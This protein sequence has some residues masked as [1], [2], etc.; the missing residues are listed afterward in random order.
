MLIFCKCP[1]FQQSQRD[2]G[3]NAFSQLTLFAQTGFDDGCV[4]I[5]NGSQRRDESSNIGK[6]FP[7]APFSFK[8]I[9]W[10]RNAAQNKSPV[11]STEFIVYK[12]DEPKHKSFYYAAIDTPA[13]TAF[14]LAH[15]AGSTGSRQRTQPKATLAYSMPAPG[16][17]AIEDFCAF[18]DPIYEQIKANELESKQLEELLN[19]LLPRLMSGEID[20]SKVD[21]T[22]LNSHL[23]K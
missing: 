14:F 23:P 9:G 5:D 15:V 12:P 18:A 1:I 4:D 20:V 17:E 21:L 2:T 22:Q 6:T 10:R 13:F 11:C 7:S 8:P 16:A 19:V 3:R